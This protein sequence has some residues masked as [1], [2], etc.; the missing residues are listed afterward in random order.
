MAEDRKINIDS[1][2]DTY[3]GS[4]GLRRIKGSSASPILPFFVLD[5]MYQIMQR[6]LCPLKVTFQTKRAMNEWLHSYGLLNRHFFGTLSPAQQDEVID[7]MD[8]FSEKVGN[9]ITVTEVA[10]MNQLSRYGMEAGEQKVLASAMLC[11][12]LAQQASVIW[13]D[14]YRRANRYLLAIEH[15]SKQWMQTYFIRRFPGHINP[16]EDEGICTAVD[17]LCKKII[18]FLD[19]LKEHDKD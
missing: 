10:V 5:A 1:L 11:N 8:L 14:V 12:I 18:Y 2:V 19:T 13:E 9:D 15:Q 16:N 3:I 17:V 6:E 7:I 4:L